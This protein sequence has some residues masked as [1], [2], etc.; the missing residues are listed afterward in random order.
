MFFRDFTGSPHLSV[1]V[2]TRLRE[3][4]NLLITRTL[5]QVDGNK[6]VA[7]CLL[8]INSQTI[9]RRLAEGTSSQ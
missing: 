4:E 5:E 1:S 9:Y 3:V 8:G 2:G 6:Q 7:A